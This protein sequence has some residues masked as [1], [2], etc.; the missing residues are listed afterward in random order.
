MG[1]NIFLSQITKHF[2]KVSKL[3]LLILPIFF[4]SIFIYRLSF[5]FIDYR[6]ILPAAPGYATIQVT[7]EL[8]EA[9]IQVESS[10]NPRAYNDRTKARGLTQITPIAWRELRKHFGSKYANLN[11]WE[12]MCKSQVAREA[13][14]DY[15]YH[16]QKI[17]KA[18]RI[19]VTLDNLLAAY[20][21][22]PS[23]LEKNGIHNAPRVVK[24]YVAKVKR[25]AQASD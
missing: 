7:P 14:T 8:L 17:L 12:D 1:K 2:I 23:N 24:N 15:L 25:L 6:T 16:L 10:N 18:K 9:L 19:P 11:F 21:W 13:G 20:V 22:G 4:A 5:A 3:V